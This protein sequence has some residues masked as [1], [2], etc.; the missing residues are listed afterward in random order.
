MNNPSDFAKKTFGVKKINEIKQ[1]KIR[2]LK[3]YKIVVFTPREAVEIVHKAMAKAGAGIIGK[4]SECSYRLKG[5]GT[6]K[7]GKGSNPYLGKRGQLEEVDETRL[8]MICSPENLNSVVEAMLKVHPYEE[9]AYDIYEIL[10]GEKTKKTYAVKVEL[11]K[12]EEVGTLVN[13]INRRINS[14]F[15]P[16]G[17]AKAKTKNIIIDFSGNDSVQTIAESR[18][19]KTLYITKNLNRAINIRLL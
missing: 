13:R 4:Y 1:I 6:F 17:L 11:K 5:K 15:M 9:P 2:F 14:S 3:K 16:E 8:E 12:A 7:G 18:T 19:G 10:T